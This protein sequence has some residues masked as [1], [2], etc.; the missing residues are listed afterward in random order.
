[1]A[2][3][4]VILKPGILVSA[5]TAIRGGVTYERKDLET[6]EVLQPGSQVARWETT[7]TIED[8]EVYERAC[9]V[10]SKIGALIRQACAAT[11]GFGLICPAGSEEKLDEA[12]A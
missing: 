12:I 7:R 5:K 3:G 2:K 10:R 11:S 1:M 8:A 4:Q 9:K 6:G